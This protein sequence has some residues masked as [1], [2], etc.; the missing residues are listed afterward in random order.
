MGDANQ[1]QGR[2]LTSAEKVLFGLARASG[3]PVW[4]CPE[5][6]PIFVAAHGVCPMCGKSGH[7]FKTQP[8]E[9]AT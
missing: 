7:Q 1:N 4:V 2:K 5:G 6:H 9:A 3:D 8:Q